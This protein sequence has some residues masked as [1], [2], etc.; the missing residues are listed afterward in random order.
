VPSLVRGDELMRSRRIWGLLLAAVV[1]L[2]SQAVFSGE[3]REGKT[4]K[5]RGIA[6]SDTILSG[7][8]AALLPPDRYLVESVLPPGQCPGHYD[9]KLT[10]I[11]KMKKADLVVAFR[12]MPFMKT[13][14]GDS[15][16]LLSVDAEG[17]NWMAPESYLHGLNF[18]AERLA[19]YFPEDRDKILSRRREA[20]RA[21][22][23]GAASL[24]QRIGRAGLNGKP[25]IVSSLQ[26]EPLEWMGFRVAEEY[27]RP[28]AM[29]AQEVVRLVKIGREHKAVAVVDNLQS[30]PDAGKGIAETL[31]VPHL[32]LTNFPSEK[33]Y[34]ATLAENVN[35]V[36]NAVKR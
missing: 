24:L 2:F 27:G 29:S 18:L 28:E 33:G 13:A 19:E 3:L 8:I 32:V 9:I 4:G 10:D 7:M 35:L 6:T 17:R 5:V 16:R 23:E 22:K 14:T 26:K 20:V 15:R 36:M 12:G 1:L 31:G 11:E 21:V 30:G 25:V 34:L